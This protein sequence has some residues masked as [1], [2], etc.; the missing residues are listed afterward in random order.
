MNGSKKW[1]SP[2]NP[3]NVG[4]EFDSK[5]IGNINDLYYLVSFYGP[6]YGRYANKTKGKPGHMVVLTGVDVNRNKVYT[7][8]PWGVKGVQ[9][10]KEFKSNFAKKW[11]MYSSYSYYF[12][13]VSYAKAK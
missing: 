10:F 13:G 5:Q 11:Y 3:T 12:A 6:M 8:N 4:Y 2:N 7:N 1:N 9:T